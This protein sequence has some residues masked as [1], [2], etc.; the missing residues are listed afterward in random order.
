MSNLAQYF[1]AITQLC[2]KQKVKKLYAFGYVINNIFTSDSQF[3]LIVDFHS[4]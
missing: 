4:T 2:G 3:D 1:S